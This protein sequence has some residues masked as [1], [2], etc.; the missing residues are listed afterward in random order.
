[1]KLEFKP[2]FAKAR[3]R[4]DSYWKKTNKHPLVS[5]VIP[6]E[7]V[8]PVAKPGW[9]AG[10]DGNFEPVIEKILQWGET[11]EFIGDAIPFYQF[12]FGPDH[13]STFL[14]A[15]LKFSPDSSAT[16][17][18]VPYVTDWD[19]AKLTFLRSSPWWEKTV[20]FIRALRKA[21]DGKMLIAG[22]TMVA[23]MDSLAAIRGTQDILMDTV[24]CP[25]K[26]LA[27][28]DRQWLAYVEIA[29]ELFK[30]LN[31]REFGSI[32][33]HGMYSKGK[34]A[35]PQCDF[36][37]MISPDMFNKFEAPFKEKEIEYLDAS[38]YH[39]DGPGAIV[40]LERMCAIKKLGLIQWVPGT[41]NPAEMDWTDL[42]KRIDSLGKGMIV[43]GTPEQMKKLVSLMKGKQI[44][45]KTTAKTRK[46]AEQACKELSSL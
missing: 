7:G 27:A 25:E 1:M 21:V 20:K 32:N 43:D 10:H 29:D 33:R 34:I 9:L 6:K 42:Y 26:L 5:V 40:H 15:D 14:G 31:Y 35:I 44:F 13:F 22:P 17:W 41:G 4:W 36:S 38:E 16:S 19:K 46:E 45:I 18:A 24:E 28:Q 37:C 8:E 12:E 3:E 2:D 30:E 23:G 39:L 11:H